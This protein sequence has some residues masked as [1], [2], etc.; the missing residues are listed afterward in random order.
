VQMKP[1][2]LGQP[3]LYLGML[4]G[5]SVSTI[6]CNAKVLSVRR[7]II[8][9]NLMNSSYPQGING[10]AWIWLFSSTENTMAFSGGSRYR[11]TTSRNFSANSGSFETLKPS[12]DGVSVC[13]PARY[14]VP[15]ICQPAA[16]L[17]GS[18][19]AWRQPVFPSA[20]T[21]KLPGLS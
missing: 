19:S 10:D 20:S 3:F 14:R 13:T 4:V 15:W 6:K 17:S 1:G 2:M 8:F 9:R 12:L 7:S 5:R 16:P 21:T 18:S 11:P